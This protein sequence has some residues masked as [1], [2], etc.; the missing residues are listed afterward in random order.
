MWQFF[1][2]DLLAAGFARGRCDRC[3]AEFLVAF[4][5]RTR[6]L[7]S[8]CHAKRLEIWSDWLEQELLCGVPRR[9]VVFSVA[10]RL[11]PFFYVASTSTIRKY[12]PTGVFVPA[13]GTVGNGSGQL[14]LPGSFLDACLQRAVQGV[15]L[16]GRL[17]AQRDVPAQRVGHDVEGLGQRLDLVVGLHLDVPVTQVARGDAPRPGG[18]RGP[19]PADTGPRQVTSTPLPPYSRTSLLLRGTP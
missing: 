18:R 16:G 9:Q 4:G 14:Q 7:C 1:D 6:L 12:S 3:R 5:C 10:E 8:S 11:R 19:V 2:Y 13:W 17:L 15:Q